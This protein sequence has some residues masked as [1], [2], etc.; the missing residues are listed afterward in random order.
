M[1]LR[2]LRTTGVA[3]PAQQYSATYYIF[4]EGKSVVV[5]VVLI[6]EKSA[7]QTLPYH[8]HHFHKTTHLPTELRSKISS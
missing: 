7:G 2:S 6:W 5:P 8:S 1:L 4:G 3:F